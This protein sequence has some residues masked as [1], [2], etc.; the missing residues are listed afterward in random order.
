[1]NYETDIVIVGAG[2]VGSA[3]ARE[4]SRYKVDVILID[5]NEDVGGISSKCNSAAIYCGSLSPENAKGNTPTVLTQMYRNAYILYQD[6]LK[7]LNVEYKRCG[8]LYVAKTKEEMD[9]L[10]DY[11]GKCLK[12]GQV[13]QYPVSRRQLLEME[14]SLSPDVVGGFYNP[15]DIVVDVFDL[16]LAF[17]QNAIANGVRVMTGTKALSVDVDKE[18]MQVKGLQTSKGYIKARY[19]LNACGLYADELAQTTGVCGYYNYPRYGQFFVLDKN[20][21]YAPKHIIKP[22]PTELT[23]GRVMTPTVAGNVL[24]GPSADNG[25]DK[26]NRSTDKETLD[27]IMADCKRLIPA[28][29]PRDSVTQFTGLRPTKTPS[30]WT[31]EVSKV[32]KGYA[33]T[34]GIMQAVSMAPG[35][36]CRMSALLHAD[37]LELVPKDKFNPYRPKQKPFAKMTEA[38]RAEAIARDPKNGNVICRCETVTEAEIINVIH[39]EP[40]AKSLDAVKRR[41][42]A[43]MGRCQG[44]FCSPRVVEILTRELNVPVETITKNEPGSEILTGHSRE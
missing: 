22:V 6:I 7:D 12:N 40:G 37:G 34:V 35:L 15:N 39:E 20:M 42:R 5:K 9:I 18:D 14:P 2:I 21:P 8:G 17:T 10:T 24:I 16:V 29:N 26:E 44:G 31:I 27:S 43:G 25:K 23:T 36:A 1:M 41:L 32:I 38:E 11:W 3:I 30:D 13:S 28:L 4:L 33:E 19:V